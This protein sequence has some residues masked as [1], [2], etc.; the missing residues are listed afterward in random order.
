MSSPDAYLEIAQLCLDYG[1][2]TEAQRWAEEG[3]WQFEDLP[4]DRLIVFTANLY[5][6]NGRQVDADVLLWRA[7]E[8]SPSLE[9]YGQLKAACGKDAASLVDV[10]DRAVLLMRA[11]LDDTNAGERRRWRS[12]RDLFVQFAMQEDMRDLAW[13]IVGSHGCSEGLLSALAEAS[14]DS[15]PAEAPKVRAERVEWLARI[16]GRGNY[17]T[18]CLIIERMVRTRGRL[19]EQRAHASWLHD[20]MLRHKAKRTFMALLKERHALAS[21]GLSDQEALPSADVFPGAVDVM[22]SRTSSGNSRQ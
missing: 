4:D 2:D 19:G 6:R 10:R 18:A 20:L 15:H 1:R 8:R 16:G 13:E 17:E 14:E 11:K 12:P 9:L 22:N 5:R 7:F 21:T 3:L